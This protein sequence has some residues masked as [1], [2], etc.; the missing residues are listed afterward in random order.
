MLGPRMQ[1]MIQE[2]NSGPYPDMLRSRDLRCVGVGFLRRD[3]RLLGG[4]VVVV[5]N[6]R[7]WG[8]EIKRSAVEA[9]RE[10]D[11]G[12]FGEAGESREAGGWQWW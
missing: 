1:H 5:V 7:F 6:G 4:E 11:L 3:R 9:Q 2:A 12:F 10:L 8:K